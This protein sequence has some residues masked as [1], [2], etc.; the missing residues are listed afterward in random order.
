MQNALINLQIEEKY[1]E[2]LMNIGYNIESL[3]SE[4]VSY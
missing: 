2:A 4:E 3:Y 1:K